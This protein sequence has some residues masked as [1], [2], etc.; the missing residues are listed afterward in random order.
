MARESESPPDT[1]LLIAACRRSI[2]YARLTSTEV[3]VDG[4]ISDA[5]DR[6]D[7][8]GSY[9][10]PRQYASSKRE[11]GR[12]AG[13][14]G[15]ELPIKR[16]GESLRVFSAI[17]GGPAAKAGIQGGDLIESIDDVAVRGLSH[18]EV[19]DAMRGVPGSVARVEIRRDGKLMEVRVGREVVR[20]KMVRARRFGAD[21]LYIRVSRFHSGLVASQL[22]S[23]VLSA[24]ASQ[25]RPKLWVLD[26]R[27]NAGG[28]LSEVVATASL[29]VP[30][31]TPLF[32]VSSRSGPKTYT[33]TPPDNVA[34]GELRNALAG[35]PLVVLV[36]GGTGSG[37]EALARVLREHLSARVVGEPTAQIDNVLQRFDLLGE[38]AVQITVGYIVSA[39]D[40][41]RHTGGVPLDLML[42]NTPKAEF[43]DLAEDALLAATLERF[44]K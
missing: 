19:I 29:F 20:P 31:G 16:E 17:A 30:S 3:L 26:L 40:Q 41:R 9:L 5:I 25:P 15:L 42:A 13:A 34:A 28:A 4:C 38:A 23:E 36:D 43:G 11:Q 24:L 18:E 21:A 22:S 39:S 37:A 14:M 44:A 12:P 32:S 8:A 6:I 10:N 1:E 35:I 27:F 33:A 7:R 2:S